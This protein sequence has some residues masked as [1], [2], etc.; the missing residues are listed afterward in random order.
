ME[1]REQE[2][3][4]IL[5]DISGYT[6][7]M[8]ESQ[9]AAVHGQLC[10][11]YLIEA[12]LHEVNVPLHLQAIE[13]DA[14][15]LYAANPRRRTGLEGDAGPDTNQAG[16]FLRGVYCSD[17]YRDRGDSVQVRYMKEQRP[18]VEGHRSQRTRSI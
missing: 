4:L 2:V 16:A 8:V 14:V 5:A 17:G 18:S 11:T 1:P 3:V 9:L 13:G 12:M 7:F 10:I 6:R 15:F